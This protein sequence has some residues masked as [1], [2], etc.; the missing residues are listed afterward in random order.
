M[1]DSA[2]IP[3]EAAYSQMLWNTPLDADHAELLFR[4]SRLSEATRLVDLGCGCG[5]LLLHAAATYPGL[6][7]LGIDNQPWLIDRARHTSTER[8]L[9]NRVRFEVEDAVTWEGDAERIACVGVAHA[10][11]GSS[12]ALRNLGRYV[13]PGGYLLYGDGC[14]DGPSPSAEARELFGADVLDLKRLVAEAGSAGWRIMHVSTAD[15]REWD[16]FESGWRAGREQWLL[17]HADWSHAAEIRAE[18]DQRIAEYFDVYRAV[19]GFAY[20]VLAKPA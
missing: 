20:L 19:L 8:G 6:R 11:G 10:W 12:H 9:N 4:R 14:W 1:A 2:V 13:K 17:D 16:E 18:L 15:Q 3:V 5:E 7:G